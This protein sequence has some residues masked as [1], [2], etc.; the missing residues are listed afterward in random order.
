[1]GGF[2]TEERGL[3]SMKGKGQL[4]TY[5][6][7]SADPAY[8]RSSPFRTAEENATVGLFDSKQANQTNRRSKTPGLP[9][10]DQFT[11]RLEADGRPANSNAFACRDVNKTHPDPTGNDR[12]RPHSMY[13][14]G[15]HGIAPNHFPNSARVDFRQINH[16]NEN[17]PKVTDRLLG[18]NECHSSDEANNDDLSCTNSLL[19][20]RQRI[21]DKCALDY[22]NRNSNAQQNDNLLEET[23]V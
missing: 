19:D 5:W 15:S 9:P 7:L 1:M 2:E 17:S 13:A 20:K 12:P 21:N 22:A 23:F 8:R 3:I 14:A 18:S 4:V 10:K 6:L 11:R 16:S